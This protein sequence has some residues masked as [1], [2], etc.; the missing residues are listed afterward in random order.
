MASSYR[1]A[2]STVILCLFENIQKMSP[3]EIFLQSEHEQA[4]RLGTF[5]WDR[6]GAIRLVARGFAQVDFQEKS[7]ANRLCE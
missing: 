3:L 1:S 4:K 5:Y 7:D 2:T 6:S